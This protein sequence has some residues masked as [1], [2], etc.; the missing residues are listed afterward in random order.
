MTAPPPTGAR[1]VRSASPA[2]TVPRSRAASR[3]GERPAA[4]DVW[5]AY[6]LAQQH[7]ELDLQLFSTRMNLFLVIQ[8]ALAALAGGA[9]I[10]GHGFTVDRTAVALFGLALAVGWLLVAVSSYTWVKTWRSHW[11]FLG[12]ILWEKTGVEVSSRLFDHARRRDSHERHY[13]ERHK[14]WRQDEFVSWYARPTFVSCC[15]PVLFL[16]GWIYLGWLA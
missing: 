2:E 11:I 5:E 3:S 4:A 9:K 12:E 16:V 15:L 6:K 8:S 13:G 1:R 10:A 7:Y 14:A